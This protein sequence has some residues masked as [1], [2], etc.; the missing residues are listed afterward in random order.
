ML[1]GLRLSL[2]LAE[3]FSML[4]LKGE[5]AQFRGSVTGTQL[6]HRTLTN[7]PG[8]SAQVVWEACA[9]DFALT[10]TECGSS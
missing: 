4:V 7:C 10:E 6:R 1:K 2:C 3:E 5:E 9:F 8:N